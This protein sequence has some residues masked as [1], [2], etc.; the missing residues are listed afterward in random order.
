MSR[1][2]IDHPSL[3]TTQSTS[4]TTAVAPTEVSLPVQNTTGFADNDFAVIGKIG[5]ENSEIRKIGTI[6]SSTAM[7]V[8]ELK[9]P[10]G[11]DTLISKIDYDQVKIYRAT[12]QTGTYALVATVDLTVDNPLGTR[13][14]DA[15]GLSTSWYKVAYY[16]SDSF[17]TSDYSDSYQA[18]AGVPD[19][20]LRGMQDRII[21]LIDDSREEQVVRD[22]LTVWINEGYQKAQNRLRRKD[23]KYRMTTYDGTFSNGVAEYDVPSDLFQ[24]FRVDVAIDGIADR[25]CSY[26]DLRDDDPQVADFYTAL[27]PR[28]YFIDSKIGFKPTPNTGTY[29]LW[30]Y[31]QPLT[32]STDGDTLD[33]PFKSYSD[34]FVDYAM[35]RYYTKEYDSQRRKDHFDMWQNGMNDF[36]ADITSRQIQSPDFIA[37]KD[38]SYQLSMADEVSRI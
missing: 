28:F 29:K 9:F 37:I 5:D 2:V 3:E 16:N 34:L 20:S 10:H 1:I 23:E 38:L 19:Y 21:A 18:G 13:Y 17:A 4:L 7:I 36:L 22:E 26:L 15:S 30:Y 12:S 14:D 27:Q 35:S 33:D 32:L 31:Q 6:T 25:T 11:I 24:V 8:A